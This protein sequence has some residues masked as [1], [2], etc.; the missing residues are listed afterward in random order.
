MQRSKLLI[1]LSLVP[2]WL[3]AILLGRLESAEICGVTVTPHVVA[4]SMMYRKPRDPDLAAKVQLFVKGSALPGRVDGKTPSEL[5]ASGDWAWHDLG[6]AV[7]GTEDSLSVWTWNGKSSRWGVGNSCE[8]EGEGLD[9]TRV[10]IAAPNRW[11][12]AITFLA[13]EDEVRPRQMVAHVVNN[14]DTQ[15]KISSVQFWLPRSGATWQTLYPQG[16]M[17]I[18][19]E[20][21]AGERGIVKLNVDE[22]WPLTYAAIELSTDS[23]KLWEHLRIKTERFD[24][25][26]GWIG[27]HLREESYLKLLSRLHVNCGQ[28][29]EVSGYTDTELFSRIR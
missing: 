2:I 5:L 19:V 29:Q 10:S 25:S 22:P 28:I 13:N 8:V 27:D 21:P 23:G 14:S 7:Q 20:I 26:G 15:M 16:A 1:Q 12:S 6:T 17:A 9:K 4:E 24:I 18:D 3:A 11:I